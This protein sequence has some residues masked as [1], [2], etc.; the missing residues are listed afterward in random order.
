MVLSLAF[1]I[2]FIGGAVA[3][4]IGILIF[5]E[6]SDSI[7]C[8]ITEEEITA[9]WLYREHEI[10][11]TFKPRSAFGVEVSAPNRYET[12]TGPIGNGVSNNYLFK[13]LK[14]SEITGSDINVI[15][16]KAGIGGL[17][18]NTFRIIDG[19]Y[20]KDSLTDFVPG[21]GG[22][23]VKGGGVLGSFS[24]FPNH[25]EE[26]VLLNSINWGN[27]IL[28][29]VTIIIF[30][31]DTNIQP[32]DYDSLFIKEINVIG[33]PSGDNLKWEFLSPVVTPEIFIEQ[34]QDSGFVEAV[35]GFSGTGSIEATMSC[36]KA[37]DTAWTVI[38]I[39]PVALFFVLFAIFGSIGGRQ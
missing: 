36:E 32:D 22:H 5:S 35:G 11:L 6:V 34:N 15:W 25:A 18:S 29:D 24:S 28:P 16:E 23:A 38:G 14:K 30:I 8:P 26:T 10:N 1:I 33:T 20:D 27:S 31:T 19:A 9:T 4:L 39:L 3:L 37:K 7:I 2:A 13:T 21:A 17:T 12:A